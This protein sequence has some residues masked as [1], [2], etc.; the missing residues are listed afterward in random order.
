MRGYT[1]VYEI[2]ESERLA[3][4]KGVD[5]Y[6]IDK[7]GVLTELVGEQTEIFGGVKEGLQYLQDKDVP[8]TI[9]SNNTS[10]MAS[11]YAQQFDVPVD[12]VYTGAEATMNYLEE[13][14]YKTVFAIYEEDDMIMQ[15]M[16][17][18]GYNVLTTEDIHPDSD[19]RDGLPKVDAV[20]T[21][22]KREWSSRDIE[23][24]ANAVI[25]YGADL[26]VCGE[27]TVYRV[28]DAYS[29]S[30][31]IIAN[32]IREMLKATSTEY[33]EEVILKPGQYFFEHAKAKLGDG[34]GKVAMVGDTPSTDMLV[35]D[36]DTTKI[37]ILTNF[38]EYKGRHE[39]FYKEVVSEWVPEQ[40]PD[41]VYDEVG[42]L[43][44]D[45]EKVHGTV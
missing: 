2:P 30:C 16:R 24:G 42:D 27:D 12:K 39:D 6:L 3:L 8:F 15:R 25:D 21:G 7:D 23:A 28:N 29:A 35:G 34:I 38:P 19:Q 14:G 11:D 1:I 45:L 4:L 32:G 9:A 22:Y 20:L 31:G 43:F 36:K 17:D 40:R 18:A 5:G 33:N 44:K 37:L 41:L 10:K 13:K 26:L